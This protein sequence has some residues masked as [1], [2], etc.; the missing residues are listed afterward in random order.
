MLRRLI[1]FWLWLGFCG[2]SLPAQAATVALL[3]PPKLEGPIEASNQTAMEQAVIGALRAQQFDLADKREHETI[4]QS[5]PQL[6]DCYSEVC[7]ER[8]GRLEATQV[9]VRYRVKLRSEAPVAA[10]AAAAWDLSVE[11]LDVEVGAMGSRLSEECTSCTSDRVVEKLSDLARRAVFEN[12]ARPRGVLEIRTD[13]IGAAVFVDGVELGVTPYKRA[14]FAGL[15][16]LTLRHVGYRSQQ[17]E[18]Q[19][20]DGQKQ[21]VEIQLSPGTDPVKVVVVE[22]EK[23]PV[24]KKWWFWVALGGAVAVAAGVTAGIVV[25]T[26]PTASGDRTPAAYNFQF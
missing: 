14:V 12:A 1:I 7:L 19:V 22:K 20:D 25:G 10:T 17:A 3:L 2:V 15:H 13:P 6:A 23:T 4:V 24:Y 26:R 21:R 18:T 16:K 11:L 8:L 9:V 5:E